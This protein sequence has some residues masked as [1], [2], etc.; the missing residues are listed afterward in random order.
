MKNSYYF[1]TCSEA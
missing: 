1:I